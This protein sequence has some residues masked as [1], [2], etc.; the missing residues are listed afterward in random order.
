MP[1]RFFLSIQLSNSRTVPGPPFKRIP[2]PVHGSIPAAGWIVGAFMPVFVNRFK[3][4]SLTVRLTE[5]PL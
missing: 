4:P 5:K 1:A 3:I 2:E